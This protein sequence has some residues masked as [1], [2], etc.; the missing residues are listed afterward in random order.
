MNHFDLSV[1]KE[2]SKNVWVLFIKLAAAIS[3][4]RQVMI[5]T[6]PISNHKGTLMISDSLLSKLTVF[7][8]DGGGAN[9]S[10]PMR[11]H[12]KT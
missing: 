2:E 12:P 7:C 9:L 3:F 1:R 11:S 4:Y 6:S 8:E 5:L 10:D